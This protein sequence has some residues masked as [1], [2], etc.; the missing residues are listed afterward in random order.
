MGIKRRLL[1]WVLLVLG[2]PLLGAL[3]LWLS[4]RMEA[5]HG[6]TRLSSG[7]R[8]AGTFLRHRQPRL[9]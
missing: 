3:A 9:A 5:E 4:E 1:R 7:L 6:T 2:P 8:H